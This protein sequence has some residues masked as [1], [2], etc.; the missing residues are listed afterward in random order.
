MVSHIMGIGDGCIGIYNRPIGYRSDLI[1]NPRCKMLEIDA[2][3]WS[4]A[5]ESCYIL[6][7]THI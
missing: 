5:P 6:E 1:F 4:D 2:E 3:L 7:A